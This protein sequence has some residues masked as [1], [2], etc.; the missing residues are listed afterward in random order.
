MPLTEMSP[1]EAV[2]KYL[3]DRSDLSASSFENH[4]YRC[5]RFLEWCEENN[6][7]S[8][9]EVT[10][11]ELH[12]YKMWRSQDVNN[13]TLK[14]QLGTIKLFLEFC[15]RLHVVAPGVSERLSLPE[16]GIDEDVRDTTLSHEEAEAITEY[17]EKFEYASLRHVTFQ[18]FWHTGMRM[19]TIRSLDIRDFKTDE[20]DE[21][22]LDIRHRPKTGTPLKNDNRG[23]RE[24]YLSEKVGEVVSDWIEMNHPG[25]IDDYG[26]TPLICTMYGRANKT[27]IQSKIY[28]VTRPCH[29]TNQCP[30]DRDMDECEATYAKKASQCPSSVSPHALRKGAI[31]YHRNNGW[32]VQ[33]LSYRADVSDRVL[34]KHYDKGTKEDKRKRNKEF[35]D[36]L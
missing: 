10:G 18:L 33:N 24:I 17:L 36:N 32:P 20:N 19:S 25:A 14:N 26:R 28:T 11:S 1:E 16:I 21:P 31:T 23:E 27:T 4:K 30:H 13:V 6:V 22:Y 2:Q 7:T 29:Y 8:M 5:H 35:L 34:K 12:D 15:E 3:N 9:S